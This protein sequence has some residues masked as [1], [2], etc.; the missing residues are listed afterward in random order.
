[1]LPVPK[2]DFIGLDGIAHLA[3]GGEPPL[4]VAHRDAFERFAADKARGFDG[5]N[6]HWE[7]VERVRRKFAGLLTADS[8]DIALT[9]NASEGIARVT[10]SIDWAPGDS[11]VV[12]EMDYASGR[13]ALGELARFGVEVR[14]VPSRGWEISE[15]DLA[16]ACDETTRLIYVAQVNAITGQNLNIQVIRDSI[17]NSS[18]ALLVD[19]SHAFGAVP[20]DASLADFVVSANYKFTLGIHDGVFAW[21]RRRQPDFTPRGVG[22]WAADPGRSPDAFERKADAK[23]AEFGNV[24][25]LSAYL[26]DVSLTYLAS[27]GIDRIADHVRRLSGRLIDGYRDLGLEVMTPDDP[28]RRAGNACF[29]HP[30][31]RAIMQALAKRDIL[32]WADHGRVRA[33]C[34]LFT[35]D[36]DVDRMM[37][38]LMEFRA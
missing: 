28:N 1:M 25:H 2:S 30:D 34:H 37:D 5:Y 19:A 17:K 38:A 16:D 21:N 8:G 13:Y 6:A 10:G 36:D 14:L 15:Q 26:L 18:A 11:V 12:A 4:L 9:A 35:S 29:A 7:T 24:G 27:Q 31:C 23:R 20:V 33:S 3:A 32:V 22:W